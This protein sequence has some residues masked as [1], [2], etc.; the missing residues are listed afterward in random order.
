MS[1]IYIGN[2]A[3]LDTDELDN[4]SYADFCKHRANL[5]KYY[6]YKDNES[7]KLKAKMIGVDI[8][9]ILDDAKT[10]LMYAIY[11][12]DEPIYISMVYG[13]KVNIDY[14]MKC[15]AYRVDD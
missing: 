6:K 15:I 3:Y 5:E 10:F 13:D 11:G 7:A 1:M 2:G 12:S 4:E 8:D 9:K 14:S